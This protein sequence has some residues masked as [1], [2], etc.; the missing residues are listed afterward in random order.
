M[1]ISGILVHTKP[2]KR[3]AVI[4]EL[5]ALEGVEVHHA[6]DD[7]RLV[8]TVEDHGERKAGDALLAANQIEGVLSASL[9]YHHF[10]PG[11]EGLENREHGNELI[12]A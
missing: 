1:N 4:G 8:V 10:E 11:P 9:V 7:G 3:V 12:Q 5:T 6:T 2:E